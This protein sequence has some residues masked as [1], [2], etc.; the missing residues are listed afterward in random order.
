MSDTSIETI[1]N[2]KELPIQVIQ[3][4]IDGQEQ[5][6]YCPRA[7]T[8]K[9]LTYPADLHLW[10]QGALRE[11]LT[12]TLQMVG[13]WCRLMMDQN[14]P[15]ERQNKY[16]RFGTWAART[17]KNFPKQAEHAVAYIY[18]VAMAAEGHGL[19]SGF[20][21]TNAHKDR[22]SGNPEKQTLRKSEESFF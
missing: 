18:N 16:K 17:V 5:W 13:E 2:Q 10:S 12:G 22:L 3:I 19:L 21:M 15:E 1:I 9:L 20:G 11:F 6:D 4:K 8:A 7:L 14:L